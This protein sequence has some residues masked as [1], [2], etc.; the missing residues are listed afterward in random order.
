VKFVFQQDNVPTDCTY[1]IIE[2][3]R[4]KIPNFIPPDMWPA[5]SPDLDPVDYPIWRLLQE[6]VLYTNE[7]CAWA[8]AATDKHPC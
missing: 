5:N 2:L 3:L 7:G 8:S 4:R 6:L 1:Q